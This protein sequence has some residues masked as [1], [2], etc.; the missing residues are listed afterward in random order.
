[1]SPALGAVALAARTAGRALTADAVAALARE[2]AT[3]A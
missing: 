3:A 2:P 1:M